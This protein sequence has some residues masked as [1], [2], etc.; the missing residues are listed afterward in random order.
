MM[1]ATTKMPRT[2]SALSPE[3]LVGNS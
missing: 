1:I 3:P 2:T